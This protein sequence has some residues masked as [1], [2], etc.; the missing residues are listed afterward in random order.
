MMTE[1][2]LK[3]ITD[4]GKEVTDY[5]HTF[6]TGEL[7]II[8]RVEEIDMTLCINF[9]STGYNIIT[10]AFIKT[11]DDDL[12]E[13]EDVIY[14]AKIKRNSF[15]SNDED[16]ERYIKFIS[17]KILK[18]LDKI[19]FDYPYTKIF[20]N[21]NMLS[22][23]VTYD[24]EFKV[25]ADNVSDL[26][27]DILIDASDAFDNNDIFKN[28]NVVYSIIFTVPIVSDTN[29]NFKNRFVITV[30]KI[31]RNNGISHI[32]DFFFIINIGR[33]KDNI[34]GIA[35][36]FDMSVETSAQNMLL[37]NINP[38]VMLSVSKNDFITRGKVLNDDIDI[39]VKGVKESFLYALEKF[40]AE[41]YGNTYAKVDI[42]REEY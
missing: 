28:K 19:D 42:I 38:Y 7:D 40:Y 18:V 1:T 35:N 27:Y 33:Y 17:D 3:L 30:D 13:V 9:K 37:Q 29:K 11:R 5:A 10:S 15:I 36:K 25:T 24:D 4:I 41:L 31:M 8:Y 26:L 21:Q 6:Y 16:K 2:S 14:I 20:N 12:E 39:M 22:T 34:Y 32:N 23:N